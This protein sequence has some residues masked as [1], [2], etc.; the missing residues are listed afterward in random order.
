MQC[1]SNAVAEFCTGLVYRVLVTGM[2]FLV[3]KSLNL[4]D[5]L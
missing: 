5:M 2:R 1:L 3:Q 4:F